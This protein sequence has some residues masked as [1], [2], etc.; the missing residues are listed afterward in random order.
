MNAEITVAASKEYNYSL[1]TFVLFWAAMTVMCG[2]YMTIPLISTFATTFQVSNHE[3]AWAG[4]AF[5]L[6]FAGGCLFYGA[7]SDRY[8]RKIIIVI[9]LGVLSA[10]TISVGFAGN[11]STLI[12]LRAIQGAAA[13]TF[14]PVALAYTGDMF[15]K[16]KRGTTIGFISTGFL[17]AGIIGQVLSSTLNQWWHWHYAFYFV[18]GVYFVTTILVLIILPKDDMQQP[19]GNILAPFKQIKVIAQ[20]KSLLL[21]YLIAITILLSFVGMYTSLEN[22]LSSE[23]YGFSSEDILFIR[24]IGIIGMLLCPFTGR[25][26]TKFGFH[27]VL[28]GGFTLAILGLLGLAWSNNLILLIIMS[29]VF[30][31]GIAILVPTLIS[32]VGQLGGKS[33]GLATSLYTFVLFIGASLGPIL[34]VALLQMGLDSLPFYIFSLLLFLAFLLTYLINT[35]E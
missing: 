19:E 2:L 9:G 16:H 12:L 10:A 6:F 5:S 20:K 24:S 13:A 32:L 33:K 35:T 25:F 18:G 1:M 22:Y 34:A 26:V 27:F 15:P 23:V 7:L 29:V 3:A 30:V 4:S 14:S 21:C 11:L 17:L 31:S 28:R 8:G